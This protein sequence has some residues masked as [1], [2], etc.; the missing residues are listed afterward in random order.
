MIVKCQIT[1]PSLIRTVP[2]FLGVGFC[3]FVKDGEGVTVD[4]ILNFK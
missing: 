3:R 2:V 4:G 1:F